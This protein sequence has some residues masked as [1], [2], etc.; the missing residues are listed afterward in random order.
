M[1]RFFSNAS[2]LVLCGLLT[3][4]PA[5]AQDFK[6]IAPKQPVP[7]KPAGTVTTPTQAPKAAV[8]DPARQLL[9]EL[10]GLR[11]V[12]GAARIERSGASMPGLTIEALPML[13]DAEIRARLAAFVGKPLLAGDL[14]RISQIVVAWYRAHN[15]P[16]VSVS[17]PEQDVNA[18]VLQGVVTESKVGKLRFDGNNWFSTGLLDSETGTRP[19][20]PI[21]L[22]R[23]KHDLNRLNANPF[24][25]VN[26]VLAKGEA[27]GTTDI[28]LHV[29]D[30]LPLRVYAS[31]DN[32][33]LPV[34]GR[35]RYSLGLN[36]GNL[37]G[38]DQQVS[39]QFSTSPDLWR[40]R[41]RGAGLSNDPRFMAHSLTYMAP[42]PWGDTLSVFGSYVQQVPNLGPDFGQ[43]GHNT[44]ISARYA[45]DL[46]DWES[47]TQQV[48]F[49]F[50]YK[51]SDNN[52]AFGG[53]SVFAATTNV[54]Q[55][56]AIYSGTRQDSWG[57]TSL[58]NNFVFGPGGLSDGN[59]TAVFQASG[60]AGANASYVYDNVQITRVTPLPHDLSWIV[61]LSGQLASTELLPSEQ[62]GAGG[63]DSVRGYDPR[64]INGSQG[65]LVS[66]ELRS[67]A[68]SPLHDFVTSEVTDS[69]QLLAFYDYGYVAYKGPQQ[70]QPDS[71][72][73][74][75]VGVGL[76]YGIGRYLDA[77]F[78]YGWQ[79]QTAPGASSRGN[80][81]MV[82][83]TMGY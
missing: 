52:L 40:T 19:G 32:S 14:P 35:D 57:Q 81:A 44:Q 21:E 77:R 63:T 64:V 36:W 42:L 66:T 47:M 69:A 79:L 75:S 73:I 65:A 31:I 83:V 13:D 20:D 49:G 76:R 4:I 3:V 8:Q 53:V 61:R 54:E 29:E 26:A 67:P 41:A 23:L 5:Q 78:D 46:P 17:F 51:R 74:Q 33:G 62:L 59:S 68:F 1:S 70:N 34:T 10:K 37:F 25:T 6:D 18:G 45:H 22:D 43:V 38:L 82:S 60:V 24:R 9:A 39:Y 2:F 72:A 28:N 30:R 16:V 12:D 71:S 58:V 27:D 7:E 48:Q 11:L 55:F 50:D 15:R 80:L 56:L